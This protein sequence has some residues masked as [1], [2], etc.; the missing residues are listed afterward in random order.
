MMRFDQQIQFRN[1][2][3][4]TVRYAVIVN[5]GALRP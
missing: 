4:R 1:P 3:R 5:H 2:G